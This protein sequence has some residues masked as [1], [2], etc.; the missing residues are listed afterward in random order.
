MNHVLSDHDEMEIPC[1]VSNPR[2]HVTLVNADTQQP[3]PCVYDSKKGALGIFTAGTYVCKAVIQG[4]EHSSVE[5]IVHGVIGVC[6]SVC[7][8][9]NDICCIFCL[10]FFGLSILTLTF[11]WYQIVLF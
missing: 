8:I 9:S 5:Y 4:E 1:R 2:A 3:V 11:H 10:I 7:D 6:S